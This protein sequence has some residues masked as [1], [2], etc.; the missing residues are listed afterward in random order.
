[1]PVWATHNQ[2]DGTVPVAYTN[3]YVTYINQAPSPNPLA[4]KSVWPG[5]G[6]DAWTR[7][8]D[9]NYRENNM[10]VYE[11]MLQ[12]QRGGGGT[13][14]KVP[15]VNAGADQTINSST[16]S[17]QLNGTASDSDGSIAGYSW[18]KISGPSQFTISN[19]NIT[20]PLLTGLVPG[21]YTFRLSATDNL[22]ATGY[23]DV[24]VIVTTSLPSKLEAEGFTSMSGV[25]TETTTDAGG[26]QDVGYI[27]NGDWMDY[28]VNVATAGTYTVDFRIAALSYG[29][30]LQL[31]K[32]DGTVL[33][34]LSLPQ[35]G[36]YQNWQTLSA[37]IT[38]AQGPQTL[39]VISTAAANWNIN[40]IN[41]SSSSPPPA[42][43][44][45]TTLPSK[46]EAENFSSQSG[47]VVE[48][49]TDAGGGQSLGYIA[50]GDW[51]EYNVNALSAGSY[52]VALRVASAESGAQFQIRKSDG[53]VLATLTV[54]NTGGW[55]IW[56]TLNATVSLAA[57]NQTLRLVST[58]FAGWNIN[59]LDFQ[60]PSSSPSPTAGYAVLPSRVE[61]ESF[62]SQSGV[63]VEP[64]TDA[65]GGQNVGYIANGDWME[66]PLS[67]PQTGSYTLSV[68][69]ASAQANGQ[70]QLQRADGS[71]IT[72]FTT[73]NTGGWQ[74]W[75]TLTATVN[76]TQGNQILRIIST[77]TPGWNLNWI[78][79]TFN[80]SSP[81]TATPTRIEAE[82]YSSMS[83]VKTEPTTDQGG[84]LNVGYID[85]GDWMQ[86][87]YTAP[88][89]GTYQLSLRVATIAAGAKINVKKP[90]GTLL[91]AI[92]LPQTG[93]Y[94]I[95][96][97][98]SATI[99]LAQGSQSFYL[100]SAAPSNWNLNWIE[101]I[102][103]PSTASA[104]S[105]SA[106]PDLLQAQ[107]SAL[108]VFPNPI[109]DRFALKVNNP[110]QGEMK[111]QILDMQGKAV[112]V[113]LLQKSSEGLTQYYL[114]TG[115]LPKGNYIL[116][117]SIKN[118]NQSTQIIKL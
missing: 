92:S 61:A 98:V 16:G 28:S 88:S 79:F 103:A 56:Q 43:T 69:V 86:Y 118:W 102:P 48:P 45:Y 96:Q 112:K 115:A 65:G 41:F 24:D 114:S 32:S 42:T 80:S 37:S 4:R 10:N 5:G 39:R 29:A 25:Q 47:V 84:G 30:Q 11:W 113:F 90:D 23:D 78:D 2:G 15:V 109:V 89:S 97:T 53:T 68:R 72:T 87:S 71:V 62:S 59:W 63:I 31:R 77:A 110:Y 8:Y 12:Y 50:N 81:A 33:A 36:G 91:T 21:R 44:S 22:G 3:D 18:T 70:L 54:P 73:P 35:T 52:S 85:N 46:I 67:V 93:G 83:G 17:I 82:N 40:W 101:L 38:L 76:L 74:L 19:S 9:P 58:S 100:S 6:H 1:M 49:T 20:N 26:G 108:E 51:M 105:L 104:S 66:Y 64:T 95:W 13:S 14:N 107:D 117:A 60:T 99:T 111:V 27:D 75:Q 55:Q 116:Q 7:T 106:N 57:G 94:Q 34:T